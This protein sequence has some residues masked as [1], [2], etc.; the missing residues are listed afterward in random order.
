MA[1]CRD[2]FTLTVTGAGI[3]ASITV[4]GSFPLDVEAG[5]NYIVAFNYTIGAPPATALFGS[6]WAVSDAGSVPS[7]NF[8]PQAPNRNARP[9]EVQSGTI[10][11]TVP[12][13]EPRSGEDPI[14][15]T[16]TVS[17]TQPDS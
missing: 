11:G 17:I 12:S 1:Y 7:T 9:D 16:C 6:E 3:D 4:P 2:I 5:A 13:R 14:V 8:N 10:S 15:Y